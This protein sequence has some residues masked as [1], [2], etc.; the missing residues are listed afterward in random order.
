MVVPVM[1]PW[2]SA[3]VEELRAAGFPITDAVATTMNNLTLVPGEDGRLQAELHAGGVDLEV[4]VNAAGRVESIYID[5][6]TD[7][8]AE[9]E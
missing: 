2:L 6:A 1:E 9:A 3:R 7:S 4:D 5:W 8:Q